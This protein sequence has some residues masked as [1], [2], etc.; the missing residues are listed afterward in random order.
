[1]KP[2]FLRSSNFIKEC[3]GNRKR[4]TPRFEPEEGRTLRGEV[5]GAGFGYSLA[6]LDANGDSS[7]DLL[8]GAPFL[9]FSS[10]SSE[11]EEESPNSGNDHH[12]DGGGAV[13]LYLSKGRDLQKREGLVRILGPQLESRFGLALSGLGDL[14]R[15]GFGDFAVGAPYEEGGGAVYV[16]FGG[17]KGLRMG[18]AGATAINTNGKR[19]V[20]RSRNTTSYVQRISLLLATCFFIL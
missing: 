17:P 20:N 9:G 1:M 2:F 14:N 8:V 12:D 6:A 11:S 19:S 7:P 10:S 3:E 4:K 5:F 18:S 15:D 16:F 13:Y